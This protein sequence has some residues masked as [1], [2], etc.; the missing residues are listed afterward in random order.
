MISWMI[1][2]EKQSI[3][4]ISKLTFVGLQACAPSAVKPV[5][6]TNNGIYMY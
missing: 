2:N 5:L 6:T 4:Q 3:E 1:M